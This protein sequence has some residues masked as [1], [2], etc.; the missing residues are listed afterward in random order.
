MS[1]RHICFTINNP[2]EEDR[3]WVRSVVCSYIV[4]GDEVGASGTPHIQG[5]VEFEGS[6]RFSTLK[7][8]CPR[9]HFEKRKGSPKQ[10]ADYCKKDGHFTERGTLSRQGH[11]SDLEQVCQDVLEKL[12]MKEIALAHPMEYVK[13]HKGLERLEWRLADD[14]H[15]PPRVVWLWGV[16]GTGKTREA[17]SVPE[18]YIK[19]NTKWWDGYERQPRII[20][21]D[22]EMNA[23][24]FRDLLRLLDRQPYQGQTKGGYV[25]INSP[26]IYITCEFPPEGL[27]RS[28]NQLAQIKRRITEIRHLEMP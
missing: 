3:E 14:R 8:E 11:R 27:W 26:E 23:W 1:C 15:E 2:I 7:N 16:S 22:F 25:K 4:A 5:Y 6:K 17:C 12:P 13:Y 20:I 9:G 28:G 18:F 21:D 24:E 19:D 10:A